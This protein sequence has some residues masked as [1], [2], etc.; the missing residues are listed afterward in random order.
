MFANK[1][2]MD[3]MWWIIMSVVLVV[4]IVIFILIWFKGSGQ[5]AFDS[6]GGQIGGLSDCDGDYVKD[7]SDY[8]LCN[9][10]ITEKPEGE[11]K[12]KGEV[13]GSPG[14]E[15]LQKCPEKCKQ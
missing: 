15:A 4:V 2:A 6:I 9:P 7:F 13:C 11:E 10:A 3:Q 1:K 14:A 12:P 8:C 5:K